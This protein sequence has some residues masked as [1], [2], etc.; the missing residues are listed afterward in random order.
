MTEVTRRLIEQ[1]VPEGS[2]ES[3]AEIEA[4]ASLCMMGVY[5]TGSED[6]R[7]TLRSI[8]DPLLLH[9]V[10]SLRKA[11]DNRALA[12]VS[13]FFLIEWCYRNGYL[14]EDWRWEWKG[15]NEGE[16]HYRASIPL[17]MV[18]VPSD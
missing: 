4:V 9:L 15:A 11:R 16:L 1:L 7:S 8:S 2:A 12:K 14:E 3:P 18:P 10:K 6:P 17:D 5:R 13:Q